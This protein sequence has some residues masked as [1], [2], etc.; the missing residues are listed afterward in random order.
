VNEPPATHSKLG[1]VAR[2][3]LRVGLAVAAIVVVGCIG[4]LV[5]GW[6]K[7]QR[8]GSPG[9]IANV[10]VL[11]QA[12]MQLLADGFVGCPTVAQVLELSKGPSR[13]ELQYESSTD[14]WGTPFQ[15]QCAHDRVRVF[16]MGPDKLPGTA[17]DIG[18]NQ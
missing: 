10:I 5:Y 4:A 3:G 7:F 14:P 9:P 1:K 18:S 16:S 15:I 8:S 12:T 6:G 2:S 11:R 13:S 17:D